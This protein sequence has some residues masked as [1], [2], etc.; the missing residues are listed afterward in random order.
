MAHQW[1]SSSPAL[2]KVATRSR[3]RRAATRC[4]SSPERRRLVEVAFDIFVRHGPAKLGAVRAQVIHNDTGPANLL[5]DPT[6]P[7]SAGGVFDFGDMTH[8]PRIVDPVISAVKLAQG[9]STPVDTPCALSDDSGF[10][11]RTVA[12]GGTGRRSAIRR[13]CGSQDRGAGRGRNEARRPR[14]RYGLFA[15]TAFRMS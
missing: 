13:G 3:F 6:D 14:G 5:A 15:R 9:Q 10:I 7:G 8:G 1:S 2:K 4:F 11:S 12:V